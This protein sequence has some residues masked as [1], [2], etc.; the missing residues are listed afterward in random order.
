[1]TEDPVAL[2]EAIR[3][4]FTV[5]ELAA[6]ETALHHYAGHIRNE[7]Q[8]LHVLKFLL[9][10]ARTAEQAINNKVQQIN[11]AGRKVP[12]KARGSVQAGRGEGMGFYQVYESGAVYWRRDL[13]AWW[14]Y[15]AIYAKYLAL[16]AEGGLLGYPITDET[17]TPDGAG[18]FNHFEH[19]SIYWHPEIGAFEVR[20]AIRAKWQAL[21]WEAFG[22]PITDESGTPDGRGRFNHF[23]A[24]LPDGSRPESSIYWTPETGAHEVYGAIRQRWAELGWERSYLGY[25]TTGERDWFDKDT[26]KSGRIS[27]FERGAIG[28]TAQDMKFVEIPDRIIIPSGRIGTSAVSGWVELVL[29]SAGTFHYRGHLHDSGFVG[30]Y[31]TVASALK[32]PGTDIGIMARKEANVGGTIS[33]DGRDEDWD[34][35]GYDPSIREYWDNFRV[36]PAMS[37]TLKI[38]WAGAEFLGFVFLPVVAA[39][40]IIT[41]AFGGDPPEGQHCETSGWHTV[42]DGNNNTVYEP[43][44][45]RCRRGH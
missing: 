3:G 36:R 24:I 17:G 45:I 43:S 33:F 22:Y 37:T 13:G 35:S 30:F 1:M 12:G 11:V 18:R 10:E 9:E 31:C 5:A 23:R 39:V 34:D 42:K 32:I 44:G 14:V 20:G 41:L 6:G 40:T 16:G 26:G 28:W 19:G 8:G 27:H 25:P 29:T 15:G 4:E 38:E 7:L 21:G 2:R